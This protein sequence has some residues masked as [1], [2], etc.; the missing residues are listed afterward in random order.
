MRLPFHKADLK[1]TWADTD[2]AKEVLKWQ[3]KIGLEQGIRRS[4]A[5]YQDNIR[6]VR[7]VQL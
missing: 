7:D 5:W 2:V 6:W 1:A 3:P 4:V